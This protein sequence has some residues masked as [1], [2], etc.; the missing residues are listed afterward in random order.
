M[1]NDLNYIKSDVFN[2]NKS[3]N[4]T[5]GNISKLRYN[6]LQLNVGNEN[7]INCICIQECFLYYP[8][9]FLEFI[10]LINK[11]KT[12]FVCQYYNKILDKFYGDIVEH[13]KIPSFN[14]AKFVDE[15]EKKIL[16]CKK[17]YD[18]IIFSAGQATRILIYRLW[19]K[20]NK[21]F[22]DIGSVSDM[23]IINTPEFKNIKIRSHIRNNS[24]KIINLKKKYLSLLL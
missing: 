6:N 18:Q 8:D 19:K 2:P 14:S 21:N 5:D 11:K 24:S 23:I 4:N 13:I 9:K 22:I 20:L 12:L 16:N 17:E 3:G 10:N 1:F 15:I 7:N